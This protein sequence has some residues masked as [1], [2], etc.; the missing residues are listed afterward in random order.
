ME[1]VYS[2]VTRLESFV[3]Y[4]MHGALGCKAFTTLRVPLIF[5]EHTLVDFL[6]E[7]YSFLIRWINYY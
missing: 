4:K 1:L 6:F 7:F 5:L 2:K 3:K